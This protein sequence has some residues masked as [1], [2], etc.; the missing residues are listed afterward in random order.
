MGKKNFKILIV[1][2]EEHFLLLL[3]NI[4]IEEGYVVKTADKGE[5]ALQILENFNAD[6]IITDLK[7]PDMDGI[8]LMNIAKAK[9]PD[10]DF[11]VITAFATVES[12]VDA[13]KKGAVDY[14]TKPLKDLDEL[15]ITVARVF[16]KRK[17]LQEN[18][19]LKTEQTDSL[20]PVELIFS[21]IDKVY[22]EVKAVSPAD[23]TV[24]LYGE[25]GTGKSLIARII[26]MIS[27]RKGLFVT[28]NCA[29]IPGTLLESEFFGYDKGAFTGAVS[30][31]KGKFELAGEG[32]IFL[33]EISE[34]TVDLQAK[35]LRVLQD[36]CFE[37]LGGLESITVDTRVIAATNRDLKKLVGEG[38]F[39]EDLY[40][41]LNV[42]PVSIPP[43]RERK[44]AIPVLIE[45]LADR[46]S[47]KLGKHVKRISADAMK[48]LVSYPWPGNIRELENTIER[49][50]IL[51][52]SS[53][54][55]MQ[56][57]AVEV[58]SGVENLNIK[59][60]EKK[61]IEDALNRAGGNRRV[62]SE[63]LGISLRALQ[64]KIKEYGISEK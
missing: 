9:C 63:I 15:R 5:R 26:H 14:I 35:L 28:V 56:L 42:F 31:K 58:K 11:I 43:L 21:G 50:M 16:E 53:M 39:R 4:L 62:A 45:Y 48:R 54:L 52:K 32:T 51:S 2:D 22:E 25:T 23:T 55:E 38:S 64:Y 46:L 1:D 30:S 20:P 10:A 13:M 59:S 60:V 27:G 24:I 12:A 40:Y 41:R 47:R 33:D 36:R 18:I 6:M 19:T 61:A 29:A 37:R 17:L 34:M 49:A 3:S 8:Q 44:E 7:M 57:P